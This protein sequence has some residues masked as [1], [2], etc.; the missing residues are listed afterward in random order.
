MATNIVEVFVGV[1][2]LCALLIATGAFLGNVPNAGNAASTATTVG[3]SMA[4]LVGCVGILG[5]VVKLRG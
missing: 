2:A 1:G 3:V 5:V 4:A